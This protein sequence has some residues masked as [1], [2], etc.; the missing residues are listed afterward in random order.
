[1]A[2]TTTRPSWGPRKAME[3]EMRRGDR[4]LGSMLVALLVMYGLCA[5]PTLALRWD[6]DGESTEGWTAVVGA[7]SDVGSP[8]RSEMKDG[9]WRLWLPP[10]APGE[11][12]I[13][14]II[15]PPIR[16][17]LQLFDFFRLRVRL[18][19][20]GPITSKASLTLKYGR[21]PNNYEDHLISRGN[22]VWKGDFEDEG[23]DEWTTDINGAGRAG[24]VG[25][26]EV[27][28]VELALHLTFVKLVHEIDYDSHTTVSYVV[29]L[30]EETPPG[31]EVDWMV[32]TGVG[33]E[34]DGETPLTP[35]EAQ[36]EAHG[37]LLGPA[38]FCSLKRGMGDFSFVSSSLLG[39]LGDL[40]GDG[41]P[42]LVAE[43]TQNPRSGW[44]A[45][46]NTGD[47]EFEMV[48]E[49]TLEENPAFMSS[50]VA[51]ADL[52]GDG[53][54]DAITWSDGL[55]EIW[56]NNGDWT[57]RRVWAGERRNQ[58]LRGT[59][60]ADGDGRVE[61]W[62]WDDDADAVQL[63]SVD[64]DDG[65]VQR[66]L[67]LEAS[68]RD[69]FPVYMV[70]NLRHGTT[71]GILWEPPVTDPTNYMVSAVRAQYIDE[72]GDSRDETLELVANISTLH[73]VGD[74]DGD[75]DVDVVLSGDREPCCMNY[76]GGPL[77]RGLTMARNGGGGRFEL[78]EWLPGVVRT[79][80]PIPFVDLDGDG[81]LDAVFPHV[82]QANRGVV[83]TLGVEGGLPAVLS[84]D[85]G[86]D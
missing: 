11:Y 56:L 7:G 1:M 60:D 47:G 6:F 22:R 83:V 80:V 32:L 85:Q 30:G 34:I 48:S 70:R 57:W 55:T 42:D 27:V 54:L 33:E 71:T 63:V 76:F 82:G 28:L 4:C 81:V 16:Q 21:D 73:Y 38:E 69:W 5:S 86:G 18:M 14:K 62:I 58:M 9:V 29:P 15:S 77:Y 64:G 53:M 43:W 78:L 40:D 39:A 84:G 31:F 66:S 61:A 36:F 52:N 17:P 75:G 51:G 67:T 10:A 23:W 46:R 26:E 49:S 41:D 79:A 72:A 44:L 59:G 20:G 25:G 8:L 24:V 13:V 65:L 45:A 19:E 3:V 35:E 74:F 37:D 12:L 2:L 50:Q 68:A